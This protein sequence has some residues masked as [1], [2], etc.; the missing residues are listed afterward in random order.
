M[1]GW[2]SY[3]LYCQVFW[4]VR[5]RKVYTRIYDNNVGPNH[6]HELQ[7]NQLQYFFFSIF[8][9]GVATSSFCGKHCWI[10]QTRKSR[11]EIKSCLVHLSFT[12]PSDSLAPALLDCVC[13]VMGFSGGLD[14][15][16]EIV[17]ILQC[18]SHW[19][20]SKWLPA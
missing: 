6:H 19:C 1:H 14:C 8:Y 10:S 3:I 15:L 12:P 20:F 4:I 16:G 2:T 7:E 18:F 17:F 11:F 13:C 9:N 5:T